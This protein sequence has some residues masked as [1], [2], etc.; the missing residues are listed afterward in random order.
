[1]FLPNLLLPTRQ[2]DSRLL[3]GV[4]E[5]MALLFSLLGYETI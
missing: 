4:T 2:H 3:G 5:P 1:M